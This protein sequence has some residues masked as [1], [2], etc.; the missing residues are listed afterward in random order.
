M[1][2][3]TVFS[4][5]CGMVLSFVTIGCSEDSTSPDPTSVT[6][7]I[8][9]ENVSQANTLSTDRANGT[10]PLS[11]GAWALY[12]GSNPIFTV[13]G[14]ADAGLELIA[15]DGEVGTTLNALSGIERVSGSGQF[16]GPGGPILSGESSTFNIVALPGDRLQFATMFV[17]SNDWFYAFEGDGLDLFSG[18]S[19]ISGDMTAQVRLYDAGTEEDTAPGTGPDQKPA[20]A[21]D[22]INVGA[23]DDD[24]MIRNASED[25]FSIPATSSVIKVTITPQS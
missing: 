5:L 24:T 14:M 2:T 23:A 8:T 16:A 10:I 17:Q 13:G 22:E 15:E 7:K 20:Q 1:R 11:P 21:M 3:T 19:P 9:V 12:Q 18:D 4:I 6:F 25:G